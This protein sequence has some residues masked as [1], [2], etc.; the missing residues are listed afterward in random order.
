MLTGFRALSF[1]CYGTLIDWE[2]GI[3]EGLAPAFHLSGDADRS[4]LLASYAAIEPTVE[5]EHPQSIY[6]EILEEV[7]RRL[8]ADRGIDIN[9]EQA[10]DFGRSVPR[11]PPFPDS[12]DALR[13]LG[14]HYRLI[15]LSNIDR[16][17]FAGS[18]RHLEVEFDAVYTAED[19]GTYKPDEN[20]FRYLFDHARSELG[21]ERHEILHVAQ[22]LFHD[23]VPAKRLGMTTVWI[24]RQGLSEGGDWGATARV[25]SVPEPDFV[26]RTMADFAA[27]VADAFASVS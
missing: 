5:H 1:D 26:F 24:D 3:W 2:Q 4:G 12:A 17:S 6:P 21:V 11:W 13:A 22:S 18:N 19:I 15:I 14:E 20:N 10:R 7:F 27:A 9:D 16:E 8:A 23:H 25:E